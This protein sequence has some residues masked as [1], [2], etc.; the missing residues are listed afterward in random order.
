MIETSRLR[1]RLILGSIIIGGFLVR[2]INL[3]EPF[4]HDEILSASFTRSFQG[5][6]ITAL[7]NYVLFTETHPPL[8]Y[9][10]LRWWSEWFGFGT[11]ALKIPSVI[12]G[13]ALIGMVYVLAKELFASKRIA[14]LAA[15]FTA[16]APLQIGFSQEARPYSLFALIGTA[17]VWVLW[18]F[19]Q[20]ARWRYAAGYAGISLLGLYLHYSFLLLLVPLSVVGGWYIYY[21]GNEVRGRLW[22]GFGYAHATIALGFWPLLP[23]FLYKA[24]FLGQY[25]LYGL[26]RFGFGGKVKSFDFFETIFNQ[27]IWTNKGQNFIPLAVFLSY[28][29]KLALAAIVVYV[30]ARQWQRVWQ[31][32]RSFIYVLGVIAIGVGLFLFMPHSEAYR[33]MVESHIVPLAVLVMIVLAAV[34]AQLPR[35]YQGMFIALYIASIIAPFVFILENEA[36]WDLDH[37]SKI[38]SDTILHYAQPGDVVLLDIAFVKPDLEYHL[39]PSLPVLTMVP[40]HLYD[41]RYDYRSGYGRLGLVEYE[42]MLRSR[43]TADSDE[44]AKE[45]INKKMRYIMQA[46]HPSRIWTVHMNNNVE[47]QL[48]LMT[49]GWKKDLGS[50]EPLMPL[51]LYIPENAS[52]TLQAQGGGT[53]KTSN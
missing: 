23:W 3:S 37:R 46:Y 9:L 24:F 11:V 17:A 8:Y 13:A 15:F 38:I 29:V 35:K 26:K 12:A 30:I 34:V 53:E 7:I 51:Q 45:L 49:H 14:L 36:N 42:T 6:P 22:R 31:Y 47:V 48:W 5:E 1:E 10:F 20:R 52:S 40:V 44:R 19:L 25:E 28:L 4:R 32:R 21:Y 39:P 27:F 41:S 43:T 2:L 50:D 18:R 33:P 16:I